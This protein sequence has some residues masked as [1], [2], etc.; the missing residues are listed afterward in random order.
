MFGSLGKTDERRRIVLFQTKTSEGK[1]VKHAPT[2]PQSDSLHAGAKLNNPSSIGPLDNLTYEAAQKL[3]LKYS[4]RSTE[5]WKRLRERALAADDYDDPAFFHGVRAEDWDEAERKARLYEHYRSNAN[6]P[7]PGHVSWRHVS[8]LGLR[9]LDSNYPLLSDA[10]RVLGLRDDRDTERM[11]YRY[12]LRPVSRLVPYFLPQRFDTS[13]TPNYFDYTKWQ[14]AASVTGTMASVLATQALLTAVGVTAEAAAPIAVLINWI[15]KDVLGQL[16]AAVY[17]SLISTQFDHDPRRWRLYSNLILI[18]SSGLEIITPFFP[19]IFLPLAALGNMGKNVSWLSASATRAAIALT[20]VTAKGR[21]NNNFADIIAKSSS[22]AIAAGLIGS[23]V[24]VCLSWSMTK[25]CNMSHAKLMEVVAAVKA[26]MEQGT[27]TP[28]KQAFASSGL[29]PKEEALASLWADI[30]SFSPESLAL[31]EERWWSSVEMLA[32]LPE[33]INNTNTIMTMGLIAFSALSLIN[34]TCVYLSL[35][36]V[37]I[38]TL[39]R[40]RGLILAREFIRR[41]GNVPPRWPKRTF[42]NVFRNPPPLFGPP[43]DMY[44][45]PEADGDNVEFRHKIEVVYHDFPYVERG[46]WQD[47]YARGAGSRAVSSTVPPPRPWGIVEDGRKN[48]HQSAYV[49]PL[50]P[51][52]FDFSPEA[53]ALRENI[54]RYLPT[55]DDRLVR[56]EFGSFTDVTRMTK[57]VTTLAALVLRRDRDPNYIIDLTSADRFQ[58]LFLARPRPDPLLCE[59]FLE[60]LR[61]PASFAYALH[62]FRSLRAV[63]ALLDEMSAMT[64]FVMLAEGITPEAECKAFFHAVVL[65]EMII[66]DILHVLYGERK[67]FDKYGADLDP[68]PADLSIT[69]RNALHRCDWQGYRAQ[70]LRDSEHYTLAY[71]RQWQNLLRTRGWDLEPLRFTEYPIRVKFFTEVLREK[72]HDRFG[73]LDKESEPTTA[74][75]MSRVAMTM[76]SGKPDMMITWA[77]NRPPDYLEPKI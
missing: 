10:E 6:R 59:V 16:G 13:V 22:Q 20:F 27:Y 7:P 18:A 57:S 32:Q 61:M 38:P 2:S 28:V 36:H 46:D 73:E 62:P 56:L 60:E 19:V 66:A 11:L 49:S 64:V 1:A 67:G 35:K 47:V 8:W 30:F 74:P 77:R 63:Q 42:E 5:N 44:Y 39:N 17:S 14:F 43:Y 3:T 75:P 34:H 31:A 69:R 24:G 33:P 54:Q 76:L 21:A 52:Y 40:S 68:F 53:V 55:D 4:N 51:P 65:R 58:N 15:M 23:T 41:R 9:P 71:E 12:L 26:Q 25:L 72:L 37:A 29:T 45:T 48:T 70:A 50:E